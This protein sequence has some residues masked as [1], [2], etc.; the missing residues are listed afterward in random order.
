M[1]GKQF[2]LQNAAYSSFVFLHVHTAFV[3]NAVN[4][5]YVELLKIYL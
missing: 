1:I 4:Y 2:M 3:F 5:V